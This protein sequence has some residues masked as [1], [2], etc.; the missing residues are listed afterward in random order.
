MNESQIKLRILLVRIIDWCLV[1]SVLGGGIPALYYS[2]TP[3]LYALLLMIGLL[4]INRFGH[5]S[6]THI[7]TLKVQLEQLHRHSHH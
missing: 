2:D 7:A 6:T 5:W 4:I 3:Q 1:L